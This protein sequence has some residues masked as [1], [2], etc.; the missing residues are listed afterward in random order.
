[1]SCSSGFTHVI[2]VAFRVRRNGSSSSSSSSSSSDS[3]SRKRRRRRRGSSI[4]N[5]VS[6]LV[7]TCYDPCHSFLTTSCLFLSQR[8]E[9]WRW[10]WEHLMA[11]QGEAF[12]T[13]L[14]KS[15]PPHHYHHHHGNRWMETVDDGLTG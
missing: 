10:L 12:E 14:V 1:M 4:R 2:E 5:G 6:V 13:I 11:W 9:R 8:R 3:T 7:T 15:T